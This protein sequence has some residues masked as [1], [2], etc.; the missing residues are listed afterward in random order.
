M[1]R[2]GAPYLPIRPAGHKPA[3]VP[4]F[5]ELMKAQNMLPVGITA[6][7]ASAGDDD[8]KPIEKEPNP[9]DFETKEEWG[10]A[11]REW[12]EKKKKTL[13]KQDPEGDWVVLDPEGREDSRWRTEEEAEAEKQFWENDPDDL[14]GY[15]VKNVKEQ[16]DYSFD[17][18]EHTQEILDELRKKYGD[19]EADALEKKIRLGIK[20]DPSSETKHA[21]G[22][23]VGINH[24]T[25]RL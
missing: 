20:N 22:G 21:Q 11:Y 23:L 13:P 14:L 12:W 1:A 3:P 19:Q 2:V 18:P 9:D 16:A 10:K 6:L 4:Y 5:H 24:L 8:E 15:S 25:R 17:L 7:A